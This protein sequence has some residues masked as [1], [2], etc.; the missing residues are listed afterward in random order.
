MTV[1][2]TDAE[3]NTATVREFLEVFSTGNVPGILDRLDDDA[4]WW[5]SGKTEGFA[6]TKTKD[7]MGKLLESVVPVYKGGALK[8]TPLQIVAAGDWVAVEAESYAELTNG[9]VYN[10][11]TSFFFR[12]GNGRITEVREYL[13]TQHAYEIFFAE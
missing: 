9:R 5:V 11:Q 10:P 1:T 8:I 13:D 3:Q 7:E 12:L 4:T 6:G 2:K